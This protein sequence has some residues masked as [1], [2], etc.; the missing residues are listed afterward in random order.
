MDFFDEKDLNVWSADDVRVLCS[1]DAKYIQGML[2]SI[3]Y[4]VS[5]KGKIKDSPVDL[6]LL[7]HSIANASSQRYSF[8]QTDM[9]LATASEFCLIDYYKKGQ[10]I[11]KLTLQDN[12]V[13]FLAIHN[14][15]D[16]AL[17]AAVCLSSNQ[18][19][20]LA[21]PLIRPTLALFGHWE[22]AAVAIL[23]IMLTKEKLVDTISNLMM[24]TTA[25]E[26]LFKT[27]LEYIDFIR[28]MCEIGLMSTSISKNGKAFVNINR[29][30][31][32]LFLL[33]SGRLDMARTI[34]ELSK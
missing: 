11:E 1:I 3:K 16:F 24:Y 21:D 13:L 18:E 8:D 33:F 28:K 31:A 5:E 17:D 6:S 2:T 29:E 14:E 25:K 27:E 23:E 12:S 7:F 20:I 4:I 15:A 32:G 30:S 19:S 26:L 10:S 34:A 9:L 22:F